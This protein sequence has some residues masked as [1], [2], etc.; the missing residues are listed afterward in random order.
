MTFWIFL[1]AIIAPAIFWIIYFYYKDRFQPEPIIYLGLAYIFGLFTAFACARFYTILPII[2]LADDPSFMI[3]SHRI[4]FLFYSTGVTG[5]VEEFFKFLPFLIIIARFKSFDE[6]IDGII[7]ASVIALGFA[8][9]ENMGYLVY[10]SG[11]ELFGR[12]FASPLTHTIFSSI[13]GYTVGNARIHK[14]SIF[15]ASA[16]GI[17]LAA[18]FHGIFNFFTT[19]SLLRILS[20]LLILIIWIW[21]IRTMEKLSQGGK[22]A[23]KNEQLMAKL[24]KKKNS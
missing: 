6:K 4:K 16:V 22:Q 13:W 2:G 3:E 1:S 23:L 7:Y 21:R 12:A 5:V 10:M 24:K 9:Y 8:S 18:L 17:L 20:A 14:K 15:K 19:S 11:F